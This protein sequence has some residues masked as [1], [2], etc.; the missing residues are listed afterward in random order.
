MNSKNS[1]FS[2]LGASNHT[3]DDRE[4]NDFYATEPKA[5]EVLLKEEQFSDI[6]L[7]PACGAG[8]VSKVL[9]QHG[10]IVFS[11]DKIYRGFGNKKDFFD[12]EKWDFDIITN[13]PYKI[14]LEFIQKALSIIPDG[15]K[16]AFLCRLLFLEGKRRKQFFIENPPKTVYV[17]SSRLKCAKN[18]DF[19]KYG[20]SAQAYAWYI[21]EKGFKGN[22]ILKWIN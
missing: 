16:V 6:V 21:W 1:I 2:T 17:S 20:S 11:Y 22:T 8:H 14:A 19:N 15:H 10:Y 3:S 18:G 9:Q 13:P 7:E 5:V 12:M 4:E